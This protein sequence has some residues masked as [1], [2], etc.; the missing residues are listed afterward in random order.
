ME[1]VVRLRAP[2]LSD[3][4]SLYIWENSGDSARVS[5][6][7]TP[8][9]RQQ[10]WDYVNNYTGDIAGDGQLRLMVERAA[11]GVVVGTVDLTSYSARHRHAEVGIFISPQFRRQGYALAAIEELKKIAADAIGLH[12]LTAMTDCRN[13]AS[14]AMFRK[15][16]FSSCGR[17]RSWIRDGCSYHDA[18]LFQYLIP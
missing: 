6:Q 2:E 1:S 17:L 16:G 7:G 3:V 18:L 10:L 15:A 13:E 9:S 11:D 5:L 12:S 4:D 14:A 8:V